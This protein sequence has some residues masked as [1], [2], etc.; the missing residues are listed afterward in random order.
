MRAVL[1]IEQQCCPHL[2]EGFGQ[3]ERIADTSE[4]FNPR[5]GPDI[6]EACQ[7]STKFLSNC[8]R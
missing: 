1:I 6:P 2:A 5:E 8:H 3:H 7:V 4:R